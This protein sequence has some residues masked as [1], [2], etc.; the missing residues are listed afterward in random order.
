M[1]SQARIHR[2]LIREGED[3]TRGAD[4]AAHDAALDDSVAD[5][6]RRLVAAAKAG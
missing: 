1:K 6:A 3:H 5:S 2:G 4:S